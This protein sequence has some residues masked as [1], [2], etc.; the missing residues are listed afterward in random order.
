METNRL[1]KEQSKAYGQKSSKS[2]QS[3]NEDSEYRKASANSNTSAPGMNSSRNKHRFW[4]GIA[5][6]LTFCILLFFTGPVG[7]LEN[8][9]SNGIGKGIDAGKILA[10][11]DQSVELEP[12]D[13]EIQMKKNTTSSR[14]LIWDFAAEDG[15]Y[16]TVKVNGEVLATNIG[17]LHKPLS[18]E[19]PVPSIVEIIGIKDGGGGITYGVKFPGASQNNAYFNAAPVGSANVYTISGQ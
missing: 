7:N 5:A 17:I 3:E 2:E 18:Y 10:T 6:L 16:I 15:D 8:V 19:I 9:R 11:T 1:I 4:I 12:R 14:M 13:F